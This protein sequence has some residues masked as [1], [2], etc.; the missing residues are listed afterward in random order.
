MGSA[1]KHLQHGVHAMRPIIVQPYMVEAGLPHAF[2]HFR[3]AQQL[4]QFRRCPG[5]IAAGHHPPGTALNHHLGQAAGIAHHHGQATGR[6]LDHGH[7]EAFTVQPAQC[8]ENVHAPKFVRHVGMRH[9]SWPIHGIGHTGLAGPLFQFGLLGPGAHNAQP[10]PGV[11]GAQQGES[12]DQGADAVLGRQG[13]HRADHQ[14]TDSRF[15]AG[16]RPEQVHVH[17]EGDHGD[18]PEPRTKRP[19]VIGHHVAGGDHLVRAA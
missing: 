13:L 6:G 19:G 5:R 17:P 14:A 2:A 11:S 1:L 7:T 8:H 18:L 12:I 9:V 10:Q 16:I 4:V 3:H 15:R